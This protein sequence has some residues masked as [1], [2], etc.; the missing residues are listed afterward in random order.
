VIRRRP[1]L[2]KWI[3]RL[4][5][6]D[7][8][9]RFDLELRARFESHSAVSDTKATK[10]LHKHDRRL[11]EAYTAGGSVDVCDDI[12]ARFCGPR[13]GYQRLRARCN[14]LTGDFA[15]RNVFHGSRCGGELQ[16]I[17]VFCSSPPFLAYSQQ[18]QAIC[19]A[20]RCF[21]YRRYPT[22]FRRSGERGT[23]DVE[24]EMWECPLQRL[25]VVERI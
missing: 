25:K 23:E 15:F 11:C 6:A 12:V 7:A 2:S 8:R 4:N 21:L 17:A 22:A 20:I 18:L 14:A 10:S 19:Q 16:K 5:L 24:C 3:V 1:L 13:R 9:R